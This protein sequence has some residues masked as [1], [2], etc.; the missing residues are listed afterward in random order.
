MYAW[1]RDAPTLVLP[2]DVGFK[3]GKSSA[4]QYLVLQVHYA[5]IEKFRGI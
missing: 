5:S 3:V 2:K 1:A 4:I